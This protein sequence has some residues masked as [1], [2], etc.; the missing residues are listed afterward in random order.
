MGVGEGVLLVT[1]CARE[2]VL[3]SLPVREVSWFG[4]EVKGN[5]GDFS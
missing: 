3:S 4:G 5:F 2:D 1:L